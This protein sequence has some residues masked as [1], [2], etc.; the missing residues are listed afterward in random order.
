MH[1]C[2]L[3]S[4]LDKFPNKRTIK[5]DIESDSDGL[6]KQCTLLKLPLASIGYKFQFLRTIFTCMAT[7]LFKTACTVEALYIAATLFGRYTGVA[8][9]EGL[10]CAQTVHLGPGFLAVIQRGPL[11]RGGR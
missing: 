2:F 1:K 6:I 8:F 9:I 10:F 3:Q 7:C 5:I 4:Q 11:F